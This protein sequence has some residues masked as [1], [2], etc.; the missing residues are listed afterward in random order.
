MFVLKLVINILLMTE[1]KI[2]WTTYTLYKQYGQ[3]V[4][5]A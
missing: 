1:K 5:K 4:D 2:E 3:C